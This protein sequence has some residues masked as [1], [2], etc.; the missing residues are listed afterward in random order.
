MSLPFAERADPSLPFWTLHLLGWLAVLAL[1]LTECILL[2]GHLDPP[3]V[4]REIL[5]QVIVIT[6]AG[7]FCLLLRPLYQRLWRQCAETP[8]LILAP[9]LIASLCLSLLIGF[10]DGWLLH[11]YV[12]GPGASPPTLAHYFTSGVHHWF[13]LLIWTGLYFGIKYHFRLQRVQ[14]DA[15][16]QQ[17]LSHQA[18]VN[19]L[20]YQ[21]NPHFLFNTLNALTSLV[22][23]RN[24]QLATDVI[25]KLAC[26]LRY[27]IDNSAQQ[28]I[29][30]DEELALLQS[31][32][33]IERVRFGERLSVEY[34]VE[35]AALKARVP[36]LLLQPLVEN[37]I[38]YAISTLTSGGK[39]VIEARL[40]ESTL[41]L[42]VKDNGPG[43]DRDLLTDPDALGIGLR[44]T[45]ARLAA[46]Y[47]DNQNF[48]ICNL[49]PT[50]LGI[51]ITLPLFQAELRQD[52]TAPQPG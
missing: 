40:K 1:D 36:S 41:V 39:L 11:R 47:G 21:L 28:Q 6:A 25:D 8:Q 33:D 43:T 19:M 46:L 22:M 29:T 9:A 42:S 3:A 44:N 35:P 38:K 4:S 7:A 49:S 51:T 13:V 18:Q 14:R 26:F 2:L 12:D 45:R 30:L 48:T 32:L 31:Y 20:R 24:H 50:G 16:H 15:R 34:L 17:A 5:H 37:S 27:S 23:S 52:E 10:I